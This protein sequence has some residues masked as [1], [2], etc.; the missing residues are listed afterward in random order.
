MFRK[1]LSTIL[2]LV[3]FSFVLKAQISTSNPQISGAHGVSSQAD[4]SNAGPTKLPDR[5]YWLME[6]GCKMVEEKLNSEINPTLA[7]I[8]ASPGWDYFPFSIMASAVLYSKKHPANKMY[9]NPRFLRLSIRVGDFLA[10]ES[11]QGHFSKRLAP[12]WDAYMWLEAYRLL[13]N[14]LGEERKQR[15]KRELIKILS[16]FVEYS[17]TLSDMAWYDAPFLNTSPN[18]YSI[19]ASDLFLAG[20]IFGLK[21][22]EKI[23]AKNMHRYAA[24]EISPDGFWGENNHRLPT[25]GYNYVTLSSVALYWE[26]SKD[27]AALRALRSATDF[28]EY[29][30]YPDGTPVEVINDRNRY[31]GVSSWGLFGFTNFSDG[32]RYAQFLAGFFNFQNLNMEALGRIAQDALYY[33]DGPLLNIPQDLPK[34]SNKM[35]IDAGIRKN[36]PWVVAYSA[37]MGTQAINN[38]YFL[39]RQGNLSIFHEK[40]GLIITGANSKRQPELATFQEK[41]NS[42]INHLPINSRLQ[43]NDSTDRISLAFN[44]FFS[45]LYIPKPSNNAISFRFAIHGK[46]KPAEETSLHLQL[47]LKEGEVLETATGKKVILGREKIELSPNEIGG[48]IRH[49][50]WK[51]LVDSSA[52]LSWPVYPYK[53]YANGP[54][55]NLDRAVGVI[56][57][58]L[59]LKED[60][61][62]FVRVNEKMISFKLI[63]E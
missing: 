30:T 52:Y 19:Y 36:R 11:E 49:H 4:K 46:G 1:F 28:H 14:K 34:Y 15:W 44:T 7:S 21:E 38:P 27:P 29:Y 40:L 63:A 18:H 12:H 2:I 62:H 22:W 54:E 17:L 33:H 56:T 10:A 43:M 47:C 58:P 57:V 60:P 45:D 8:E 50:G 32:R 3:L 31:W 55:T 42:Q 41:V 61:K 20:K 53:P 24:E 6:Q 37:L 16:P 51:L 9:H 59:A 35:S 48:W 25:T 13:E 26:H 39:D 5:Y 23:G